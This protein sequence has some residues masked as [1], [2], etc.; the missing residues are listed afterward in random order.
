MIIV[1]MSR[2]RFDISFTK[3]DDKIT[4]I[5]WVGYLGKSGGAAKVDVIFGFYDPSPF[6][7]GLVFNLLDI[8]HF[9][10]YVL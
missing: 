10:V 4:N 6:L 2:E 3:N 7:L 5:L 9:A 1:I 8:F